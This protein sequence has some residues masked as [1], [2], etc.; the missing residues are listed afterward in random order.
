[1]KTM[2]TH[3]ELITNSLAITIM[4]VLGEVGIVVSVSYG[5]M[6]NPVGVYERRWSV[7]CLNTTNNAQFER[8][9]AA[10]SYRQ[11][12]AIA[13]NECKKRGWIPAD[14]EDVDTRP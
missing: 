11:A 13:V 4:E 7:Q 9:Y 3:S 12:V 8:P 5:P 10:E 14:V 6:K 2:F 1:M